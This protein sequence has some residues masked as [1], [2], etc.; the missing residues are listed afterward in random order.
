MKITL[1]SVLVPDQEQAPTTIA[2]FEDTCGN[3]IKLY[4]V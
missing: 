1:T 2:V 4:Q 3:L